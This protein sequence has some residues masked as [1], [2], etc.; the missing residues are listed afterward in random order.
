MREIPIG[1]LAK[2]LG[3]D[4]D[5]VVRAVKIDLF[6]GVI[7]DTRVDTGRLRG[8]WQTTVGREADMD[9]DRLDQSGADAMMEV[10]RTVTPDKEDFLTNNLP[11]AEYWEE[12]D[13]MVARNVAR[14]ERNIREKIAENER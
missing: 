9:V 3:E 14:L 4:I 7:L 6:N 1:Q 11:Y 13:G 2:V 5:Q 12:R 8:N 10:E